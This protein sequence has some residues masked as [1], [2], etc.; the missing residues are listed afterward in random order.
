MSCH[1]DPVRTH[2]K[3]RLLD[4]GFD[5]AVSLAI[6]R[7]FTRGSYLLAGLMS[8]QT[9]ERRGPA[10]G[11]IN[12]KECAITSNPVGDHRHHAFRTAPHLRDGQPTLG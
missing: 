5:D 8:G 11:C 2:T 1:R 6:E 7:R 3:G 12:A 10:E 4:H 9:I